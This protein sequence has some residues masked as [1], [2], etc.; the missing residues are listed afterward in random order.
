MSLVQEPRLGGHDLNF[1]DRC[2]KALAKKIGS[3]FDECEKIFFE[4]I[5]EQGLSKKLAN[6]VWNTLL[7]VQR[8]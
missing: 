5:D 8:G 7:R 2:R 3:L 1:A 6:Y 4:T